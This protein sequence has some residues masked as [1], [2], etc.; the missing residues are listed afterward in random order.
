MGSCGMGWVGGWCHPYAS[1]RSPVG[2]RDC[3]ELERREVA[4]TRAP[5]PCASQRTNPANAPRAAYA[6]RRLASSPMGSG[7]DDGAAM[8][9]TSRSSGGANQHRA[10]S[11]LRLDR[12]RAVLRSPRDQR[13]AKRRVADPRVVDQRFADPRF[14]DSRVVESERLDDARSC[15]S[16]DAVTWG[17]RTLR[18]DRLPSSHRRP[19]CCRRRTARRHPRC[20]HRSTTP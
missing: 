13:G 7:D 4:L 14:A 16:R 20:C 11:A 6:N 12:G 1:S 19:S 3:C 15:V 18:P 5:M 10:R 8:N 9:S 2:A 17:R